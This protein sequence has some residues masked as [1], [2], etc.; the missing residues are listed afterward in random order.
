MDPKLVNWLRK[1]HKYVFRPDYHLSQFKTYSND[2]AAWY[3]PLAARLALCKFAGMDK[4]LEK[5]RLNSNGGPDKQA[6]RDAQ[7]LHDMLLQCALHR[8]LSLEPTANEG[9][10][11]AVVRTVDAIETLASMFPP[12]PGKQLEIARTLKSL[13]QA[14]QFLPK[15]QASRLKKKKRV[16][17]ISDKGYKQARRRNSRLPSRYSDAWNAAIGKLKNHTNATGQRSAAPDGGPHRRHDAQGRVVRGR[18]GLR[19]NRLGLRSDRL[20]TDL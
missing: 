17:F 7:M 1:N 6:R 19:S 16:H 5:A 15:E 3:K 4:A 12:R 14:R 8:F 2:N 9:H 13:I 11:Y 20:G 10:R 18:G